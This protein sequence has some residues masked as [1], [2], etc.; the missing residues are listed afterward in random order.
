MLVLHFSSKHSGSGMSLF[1]FC[2]VVCFNWCVARF[3]WLEER[4]QAKIDLDHS[5][6]I[7]KSTASDWST[8]SGL[9]QT[10]T[11][12]FFPYTQKEACWLS[13]KRQSTSPI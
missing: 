6:S 3:E 13:G 9:V 11:D 5:H 4:V 7:V 10:N 12:F 1:S 2:L 8:V